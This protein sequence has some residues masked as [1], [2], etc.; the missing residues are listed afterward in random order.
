MLASSA[1]GTIPTLNCT[2]SFREPHN[3]TF[4]YQPL[5]SG[6][7]IHIRTFSCLLVWHFTQIPHCRTALV[8]AEV[9]AGVESGGIDAALS[10]DLCSS[11]SILSGC[12]IELAGR[13]QR[14]FQAAPRYFGVG[15]KSFL[16]PKKL[17]QPLRKPSWLHSV[18][19]GWSCIS[20]FGKGDAPQASHREGEVFH[21][22]TWAAVERPPEAAASSHP[23]RTR[24]HGP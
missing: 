12:V 8:Q 11:G 6:I 10:Q 24:W 19:C 22:A 3:G 15:R 14:Q 7:E 20:P 9:L 18:L 2:A 1:A 5:Q 21:T 13:W 17:Q 16:Q 23:V 4:F